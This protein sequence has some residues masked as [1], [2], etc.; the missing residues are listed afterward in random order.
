LG[1]PLPKRPT[2][3]E[4][5]A[6]AR[7]AQGGDASAAAELCERCMPE[8]RQYFRKSLRDD[9]E[10]DDATQHVML[11]V[12]ASLPGYRERGTPFRAYVFRIAHNYALD[13]HATQGRAVTTAPDE[14]N[15]LREVENPRCDYEARA[16]R[17]SFDALVSLLPLS[18]QR[19]VRLIYLH[20]LSPAQAGRLLGRSPNDVRRLHKRARDTLRRFVYTQAD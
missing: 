5:D 18:Q 8:V 7:R 16:R 2:Q 3:D 1:D 11:Q 19:V 6:V 20:D 13:R 15:R 9:H 17:D 14:V 4:L 12:L 10:A